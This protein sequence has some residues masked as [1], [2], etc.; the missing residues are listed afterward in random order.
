MITELHCNAQEETLFTQYVYNEF[1]IN[2]AYAGYQDALNVS[3]NSRKQWVGLEGS[4]FTNTLAAHTTLNR[5]NPDCNNFTSRRGRMQRRKTN[6]QIGLGVLVY[7]DHIGVDNTL[8]TNFAY[9]YK[10][11]MHNSRLSFG[12]Q[13]SVINYTQNFSKLDQ[14]NSEDPIFNENTNKVMINFGS[15]IF[16]D[17]DR[18]YLGFSVPQLIENYLD[19]SNNERNKQLRQY[20]LTGGYLFYL[21]RFYKFKPSFMFRYSAEIPYQID[22]SGMIIYQN[23]VFAGLSYKNKD[24]FSTIFQVSYLGNLRMGVA[25]DYYFGKIKKGV[26]CTHLS[27][28]QT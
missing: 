8:Q 1:T 22:I 26:S 3:L 27:A 7:N 15:G 9:S 25:Y 17:N 21:S 10:I 12:L 4:P 24:T 14:F 18:Y 19:E 28:H 11:I 5:K 6:N 23:K 20:F 2:P 13:G 16:F